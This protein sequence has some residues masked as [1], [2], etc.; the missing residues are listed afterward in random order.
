MEREHC[1]PSPSEEWEKGE[2]VEREHSVKGVGEGREGGKRTLSTKSVTSEAEEVGDETVGGVGEGREGGKGTLSC[3]Q[4]RQFGT[5]QRQRSTSE[6]FSVIITIPVMFAKPR[7]IPELQCTS[8]VNRV[9]FIITGYW[10][11]HTWTLTGYW[12]HTSLDS[13]SM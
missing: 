1:Q 4:V 11:P 2:K 13:L 5:I 8:A 3:N 7:I 9:L 10:K 12:M 6:T